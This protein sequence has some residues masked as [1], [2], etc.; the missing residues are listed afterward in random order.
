MKEFPPWQTNCQSEFV[1]S[2]TQERGWFLIAIIEN[3]S[4]SPKKNTLKKNV[5]LF[6]FES[7]HLENE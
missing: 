4:A 7:K 2:M 1:A 5:F 6:S 3:G